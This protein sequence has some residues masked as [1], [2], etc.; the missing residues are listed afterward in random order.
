MKQIIVMIAMVLL[1]ITI[2]GF[3]SDF[4]NSAERISDNANDRIVQ[5]TSSGAI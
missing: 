3:I 2:A 1:G 4:S 5:V